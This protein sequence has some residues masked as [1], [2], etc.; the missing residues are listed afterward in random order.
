V[1]TETDGL[2]S[3][4]TALAIGVGEQCNEVFDDIVPNA[5]LVGVTV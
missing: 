1:E 5:A 3:R 4:L 2:A